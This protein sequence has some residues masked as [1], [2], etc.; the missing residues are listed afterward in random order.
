MGSLHGFL[1]A[2]A[3]YAS[4]SP[5]FRTLCSQTMYLRRSTSPSVRKTLLYCTLV[6]T[7]GK[8]SKPVPPFP[9]STPTSVSTFHL[10]NSFGSIFI[11]RG[12]GGAHTTGELGVAWSHSMPR[13]LMLHHELSQEAFLLSHWIRALHPTH[14]LNEI[15]R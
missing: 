7:I 12:V 1:C 14:Q 6:N 3:L 15:I 13:H 11:W 8:I 4:A 5:P 9:I 10:A 2:F